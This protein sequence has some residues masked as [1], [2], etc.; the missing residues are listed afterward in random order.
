MVSHRAG[1]EKLYTDICTVY[2]KGKTQSGSITRT[3][4]NTV[5]YSDVPCRV[6]Y[7]NIQQSNETMTAASEAIVITLFI[8]PELVIKEGSKVVVTR[9]GREFTYRASGKP[10]FY[11]DH[12]EIVL[13]EE[14][15]A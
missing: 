3:H 5:A 9:S 8:A 6:S 7:K 11:S 2:E 13:A 10:A 4:S 1:I 15:K 12:Q 14:T